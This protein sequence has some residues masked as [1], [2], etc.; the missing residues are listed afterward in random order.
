MFSDYTCGIDDYIVS[1]VFPIVLLVAFYSLT[2]E[3]VHH[4][5][6]PLRSSSQQCVHKECVSYYVNDEF[7]AFDTFV[8]LFN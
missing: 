1:G 4:G 3:E 8:L 7:A 6:S 5:T 2:N